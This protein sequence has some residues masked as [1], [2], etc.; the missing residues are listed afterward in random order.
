MI[1]KEC[2][3]K[4][5]TPVDAITGKIK[6]V[7]GVKVLL[8]SD[9][10]IMYGIETRILKQAVRRNIDR[11]PD[12]FMFQLEKGEWHSLR[13]QIVIINKEGEPDTSHR[14]KHP[15]YLPYVFTEQGVA[16]LSSVLKSK[17]AV[18]ANIAIMRAFVKLREII[19]ANRE[20]AA[21]FDELERKFERHDEEI[22]AIFEAIRELMAAPEEKSKKRIGFT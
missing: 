3:M 13:S 15:K 7:R 19:S 14:G 1:L 18:H 4:E 10:A 11:F 20:L 17:R 12:D 16:M 21:R 5:L 8:D 2:S 22:A 6:I 9:L